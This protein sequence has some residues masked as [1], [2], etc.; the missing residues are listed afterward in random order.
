MGSQRVV[1]GQHMRL[2]ER[3][4]ERVKRKGRKDYCIREKRNKDKGD[5]G[6]GVGSTAKRFAG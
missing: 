3:G 5:F 6:R 2:K 1:E 4:D